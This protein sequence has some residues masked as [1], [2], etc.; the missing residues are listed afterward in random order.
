M[1]FIY[2]IY[3]LYSVEWMNMLFVMVFLVIVLIVMKV[4]LLLDRV[5]SLL[6]IFFLKFVVCMV[7]DKIDVNL[8]VIGR[9]L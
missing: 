5:F 4:L 3:M 7:V 9:K 1:M 6:K 8:K 2:V